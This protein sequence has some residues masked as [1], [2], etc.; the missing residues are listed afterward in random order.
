MEFAVELYGFVSLNEN[1]TSDPFLVSQ[2]PM[3]SVVFPA[4]R[5]PLISIK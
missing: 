5:F 1:G 3:I 2:I 4:R